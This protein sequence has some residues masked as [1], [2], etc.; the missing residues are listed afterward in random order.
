MDYVAWGPKPQF[1]LCSGMHGDEYQ[2]CDLLREFVVAHVNEFDNFIYI[3]ILSPSAYELK[4]RFNKYG[5]DLNRSFVPNATDPEALE[6]IG[7]VKNHQFDWCLD[8]HEDFGQEK[9]FYV[10]DSGDTTWK[11][12]PKELNIDL[13]NG[14]E[15]PNDP[16]LRVEVKDGYVRDFPG[17]FKNEDGFLSDWM[18]VNNVCKR[19]LTF[20][21]PMWAP[22][23][24]KKQIIQRVIK[25]SLERILVHPPAMPD[26]GQV[27][28]T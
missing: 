26:G 17:H 2:T 21:I 19:T 28:I 14:I 24:L 7:L 23:D 4:T 3:P 25:F 12:D 15:D 18:Y 10:C 22:L 20:E 5:H 27:G 1:L 9:D 13:F 11:F 8:F 6:V 16:L